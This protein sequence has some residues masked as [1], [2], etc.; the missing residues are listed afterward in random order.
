[1]GYHCKGIY[2]DYH[3]EVLLSIYEKNERAIFFYLMY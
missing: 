3:I 2:F 1:M